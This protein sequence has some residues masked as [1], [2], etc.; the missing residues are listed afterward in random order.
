LLAATNFDVFSAADRV[1]VED[2]VGVVRLLLTYPNID[3]GVKYEGLTALMQ[4]N[5][6]GY[7]KVVEVL[8]AAG[9]TE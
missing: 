6:N 1:S 5:E 8:T 7:P 9:V 2:R 3:T 4:A